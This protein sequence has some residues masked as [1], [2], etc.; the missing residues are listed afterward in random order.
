M[1]FFFIL[2]ALFPTSS[3]ALV[4]GENI[5]ADVL[6]VADQQM[7]LGRGGSDALVRGEYVRVMQDGRFKGRAIALQILPYVSQWALYYMYEPIGYGSPVVLKKSTP[8]PIVDQVRASMNFSLMETARL[9]AYSPKAPPRPVVRDDV[10]PEQEKLDA[11]LAL[12]ARYADDE[13]G[14]QA[15]IETAQKQQL[16]NNLDELIADSSPLFSGWKVKAGIAP[17]TFRRVGSEQDLSMFVALRTARI[18]ELALDYRIDTMKFR[19]QLSGNSFEVSEHRGSFAV[20]LIRLNERSVLFSYATYERRK[21]GQAYALRSHINAGPLGIKYDFPVLP[22]PWTY[23]DLSYIPTF[24]YQKSDFPLGNSTYETRSEVGLR[25]TLRARVGAN[26]YDKQL[27]LS[28]EA[29][30]RPMQQTGSLGLDTAMTHLS[31]NVTAEWFFNKYFSASYSNELSRDPLRR[32]LQGISA[33]D[34]VHSFFVNIN[35]DL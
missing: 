26:F 25:H 24:D 29:L 10:D 12:A 22:A 23:F 8:H 19:D 17:A 28:Y 27:A 13:N 5:T 20:D 7:V 30:V 6:H 2:I 21:Q 14:E 35:T 18:K 15:A 11:Q 9:Q 31:S 33:T 16:E 32:E 1:H 34:M 3:L 4:R